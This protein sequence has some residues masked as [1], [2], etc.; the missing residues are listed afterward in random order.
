MKETDYILH[1]SQDDRENGSWRLH[2]LLARSRK[3]KAVWLGAI[4]LVAY[5]LQKSMV[6]TFSAR[7]GQTR[8]QQLTTHWF[9]D[10]FHSTF[11]PTDSPSSH[12]AS[13][14]IIPAN[15]VIKSRKYKNAQSPT[16]SATLISSK[17]QCRSR[18]TSLSND[19]IDS[20][21]RSWKLESMPSLLSQAIRSS[22][23]VTS[24]R[25]TGSPGSPKKDPS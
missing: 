18:L 24:A 6:C 11:R 4:F 16:F 15:T 8:C 7:G 19:V 1:T 9:R 3:L 23:M 13:R 25:R 14:P 17:M 22:T 12:S 21:P 2:C 10:K 20:P 5:V